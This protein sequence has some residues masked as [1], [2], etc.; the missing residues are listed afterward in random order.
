P[1]P[2]L[3]PTPLTTLFPV[4]LLA[5]LPVPVL[6]PVP[7]DAAPPEPL[8]MSPT[9]PTHPPIRVAVAK[10]TMLQHFM[11]LSSTGWCCRRAKASRELQT[12]KGLAV[13]AVARQPGTGRVSCACQKIMKANNRRGAFRRNHSR[14]PPR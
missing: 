9:F 2:A 3:P 12:G 14:P 6:F 7:D 10:K 5:E 1:L 13:S 4:P 11:A 8:G